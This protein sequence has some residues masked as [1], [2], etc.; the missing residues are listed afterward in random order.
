M[1]DLREREGEL[2]DRVTAILEEAKRQG[3][4]AAEVSA[5]EYRGLAVS[6]RKGE[7]ENVEFNR[8]RGFSLT[9][10]VAG[11]HG[12]QK[13]SAS[14]SD[15]RTESIQAMVAAALNLARN[16][17]ADRYAGLPDVSEQA[18]AFPDLDLFHPWQVETDAVVELAQRCEAAGLAEDARIGNSDGAQANTQQACQV[19][20]NSQGFLGAQSGTRHSLSCVLI[21][22]AN[23]AMQ[24][25]YW[26][27]TGRH[28]EV[29]A[30][31]ESI[32]K[33]AAVRT[34]RRL[35]PRSVTTGK[36]PVV[37]APVVAAGLVGH[38]M[39]AIAGGAVYRKAS[40]LHD[41][42]GTEALAAHLSIHEDP[43]RSRGVGSAAFD[44]EGV[45]T[46]AKQFVANG[47]IESWMLSSYSARRLG[48]ATTGNA[49]GAHNL[50]L[51]GRTLPAA[52][53]LREV[54]TGLYVT[55]LMGQGVNG[56]TGDYSRGASGFWIEN[57][58]LAYPVDN[59]TIAGNLKEMLKQVEAL[60]DDVDRRGN[61]QAG[62]VWIRQMTVAGGT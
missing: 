58:E 45:A 52:E 1:T 36:W 19:F 12:L 11:E 43:L 47:V 53:L 7:L 4:A 20:G 3:S 54:G 42:L 37:F 48:M 55:E 49:G 25:D 56:V 18:T 34:L 30:D 62:S 8:D 41:A 17:E 13:G 10:Y 24:R 39:S 6:V 15:V 59:V 51:T 61:T 44:S 31:P 14:T 29:L 26:Y 27:D 40:W 32:G 38:V 9:V 33:Q 57:G 2:R 60:G 46:R 5:G 50:R 22:E 35:D 16:T 28:P 21:A 23:G